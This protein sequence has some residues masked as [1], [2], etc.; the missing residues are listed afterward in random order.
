MLFTSIYV[1]R[2]SFDCPL[3]LNDKK[4]TQD[5]L[6][7]LHKKYWRLGNGK[8]KPP[9][10]QLDIFQL[11][12]KLTMMFFFNIRESK[13]CL[14]F[15]SFFVENK[16]N[17]TRD[18]VPGNLRIGQYRKN[19]RRDTFRF[20]AAK[21]FNQLDERKHSKSRKEFEKCVIDMVKKYYPTPYFDLKY[22]PWYKKYQNLEDPQ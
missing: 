6:F 3:W 17:G 16:E 2:I 8:V 22:T 15:G 21:W 7:S 1:S 14:N 4:S 10:A 12:V 13:T 18:F 19:Y 5:A 9:E 11:G 20:T